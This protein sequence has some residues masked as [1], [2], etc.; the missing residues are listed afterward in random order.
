M[1]LANR[2]RWQYFCGANVSVHMDNIYIGEAV[3]IG[4]NIGQNRTPLYGYNSPH[5]NAV[6]DGQVLVQ[7]KIAINYVS[8]EYLLSAIR[9]T[10]DP[11]PDIYG[12][13]STAKVSQM[14]EEELRWEAQFG[15][16]MSAIAALKQRYWGEVPNGPIEYNGDLRIQWGR[17]D[18]YSKSV[19]IKVVF[20][21]MMSGNTVHIIK[22]AFF[23]GRSMDT[24]ISED[25]CI[26]TFD[27]ISR[28][29][30]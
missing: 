13:A 20:G 9:R 3:A 22:N 8:H 15:D 12:K 14:T 11:D 29:I 24:I 25:P 27:F 10:S 30:I 28:S 5:F 6:S 4:Y 16:D 17:P 26:E 1:A 7:G 21:G 18:Q 2:Q 19:D 23:T